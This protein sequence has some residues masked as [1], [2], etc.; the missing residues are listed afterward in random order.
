MIFHHR[1]IFSSWYAP[2]TWATA[3]LISGLILATPA[4][5]ANDLDA[6]KTTWAVGLGVISSQEPY[7]DIDRDNTVL[8]LLHIENKYIRFFGTTLEAKLPGLTLSETNKINF[9]LLGR[10]DGAGYES[11]DSR[12]LA[13]MDKRKSSI[14]AGAKVEWQ[15]SLVN[16][17]ADWTY[18]VSGYS[19]GQ[20]FNLG[21]DRDWKLS[22]RLTLTPR[23]GASWHDSDYIDY[24]YG[25]RAH[26]VRSARPEYHGESGISAEVG[27]QA[28]YRFNQ[29]H[30]LILD[31]RVRSLPSEIKDSPL[32]DDSSENR[33]S[34]GYM[35]QF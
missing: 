2:W 27:L 33:I 32:V 15:T 18:D 25:V 20:Q 21:I 12:A 1:R 29:R 34:I 10:W 11:S 9:S 7:T 22:P 4:A 8:P 5:F 19:K 16:L 28:N 35:Y 14:W 31:A 26:E 17:S 24:Y 3:R 6:E 23:I 30:S 13:G